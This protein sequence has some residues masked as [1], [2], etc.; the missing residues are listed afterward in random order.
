MSRDLPGGETLQGA[1]AHLGALEGAVARRLEALDAARAPARLWQRDATLW[2]DDPATPEIADRLGWLTCLEPMREQAA[3]MTAFAADV[4]S[5]FDRV[6]LL[7]MG[8]SSLAPEVLWRS[9]GRGAG[10]PSLAVLDSTDPR[11]IALVDRGG[12][13]TRTLFLV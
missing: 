8:G 11:A 1:S 6:V 12:D 5:H 2:K 7:G 4:R 13:V 10:F 3:D 9:F